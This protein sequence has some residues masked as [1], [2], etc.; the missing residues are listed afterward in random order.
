MMFDPFFHEFRFIPSA[1]GL[2][3]FCYTPTLFTTEAVCWR[4]NPD[5]RL[6]HLSRK[7]GAVGHDIFSD[8]SITELA[9]QAEAD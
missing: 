8:G 3:P 5:W 7:G 9:A 6:A 1:N 4:V 2:Q